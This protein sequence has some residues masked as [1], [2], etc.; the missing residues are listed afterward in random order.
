MRHIMDKTGNNGGVRNDGNGGG[1]GWDR[2]RGGVE[3]R[4]G[5]EVGKGDTDGEGLWHA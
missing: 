4:V 3:K 2:D 5:G 1:I